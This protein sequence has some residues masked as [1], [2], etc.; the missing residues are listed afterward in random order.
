MTTRLAI[1]NNVAYKLI[2]RA[3]NQK[4]LKL[5]PHKDVLDLSAIYYVRLSE[6]CLAIVNNLMMEK[7]GITKESLD[8]A[9]YVNTEKNMTIAPM[10]FMLGLFGLPIFPDNDNLMYVGTNEMIFYGAAIMLYPE[11]FQGLSETTGTNLFVLP[12]SVHDVIIVP[13]D[14]MVEVG[15]LKTMVSEINTGKIEI[16]K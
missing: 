14:G 5:V 4:L 13:D 12:S 11:Y 9:A 15:E 6:D 10:S 7:F 16:I 2:N 3:E 8:R 1:L